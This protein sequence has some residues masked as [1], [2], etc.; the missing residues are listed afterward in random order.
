MTRARV[1]ASDAFGLRRPVSGWRQQAHEADAACCTDASS[2]ASARDT[3]RVTPG[4]RA[5]QGMHLPPPG[6]VIRAERPGDAAAIGDLHRAAFP[7]EDVGRL[8]DLLRDSPGYVPG[9]SLVAEMGGRIVGHV[10]VTMATLR[11]GQRDR[12]VAMLSPLGVLPEAQRRGIGSAL[13]DEVVARTAQLGE[14]LVVL[15]GDPAFYGR[16][17]FEYSVPHG[18]HITLPSWARPECAQVHLLRDT[19]PPLQGHVVYPPAFDALA[20]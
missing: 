13:V 14:P 1:N 7:A 12:P 6:V 20:D 11:D 17:G 2:T 9:L 3:L 15:E 10:M 4:P 16:L 18:I 19:D 8:V 5:S